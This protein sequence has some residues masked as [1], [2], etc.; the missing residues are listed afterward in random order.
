MEILISSH[1]DEIHP[2]F[3]SLNMFLCFVSYLFSDSLCHTCYRHLFQN[4]ELGLTCRRF[5]VAEYLSIK[6]VTRFDGFSRVL[7]LGDQV[8]KREEQTSSQTSGFK[9]EL[10][11]RRRTACDWNVK[12]RDGSWVGFDTC[13]PSQ[14]VSSFRPRSHQIS[15]WSIITPSH[16][17]T[18]KNNRWWL[19][20][21]LSRKAGYG[22]FM[23]FYIFLLRQSSNHVV[24]AVL[25]ASQLASKHPIC[26]RGS[27][28]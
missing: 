7:S 22:L 8:A 17:P 16:P 5:G 19:A 23:S 15:T 25:P 4:V 28:T 1:R 10:S 11:N 14:N 6:R 27:Q 13:H 21:H 2:L 24:Q 20:D 12:K 3:C 9:R 18:F 26:A